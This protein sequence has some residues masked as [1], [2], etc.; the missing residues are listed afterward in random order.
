MK[1]SLFVIIMC[2]VII[3]SMAG[4]GDSSSDSENNAA[5]QET[6]AAQ[7][8]TTEKAEAGVDENKADAPQIRGGDDDAAETT[9]P[10]AETT[11][12]ATTAAQVM[13]K[14]SDSDF[15]I[16]EDVESKALPYDL[17]FMGVSIEA[18]MTMRDLVDKGFTT[19]VDL[20][21]IMPA[22]KKPLGGY[23]MTYG[24]KQLDC[25]LN[26]VPG[27]LSDKDMEVGDIPL[28]TIS[29]VMYTDEELNGVTPEKADYTLPGG[30]R[31]GDDMK[32][33]FTSL[34]PP[35]RVYLDR[36]RSAEDPY[37]YL[38]ATLDYNIDGKGITVSYSYDCAEY[39][40]FRAT[41]DYSVELYGAMT[42]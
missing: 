38:D 3:A 32:D 34:N 4:C 13:A 9:A 1:R 36:N 28:T 27:N 15:E 22:N 8:E 5:Q 21:E 33:T 29:I 19:G 23:T 18:G 37:D 40:M 42:M 20:T 17:T 6:A 30:V 10:A 31:I 35:K 39:L 41:F 16:P 12:A 25:Y 14:Y 7:E 24:D 2:G 11:E 26:V